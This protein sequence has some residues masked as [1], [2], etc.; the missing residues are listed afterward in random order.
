MAPSSK[1]P[2]LAKGCLIT[3]Y[4][5]KLNPST[6]TQ[7]SEHSE[8][9]SSTRK[10]ADCHSKAANDVNSETDSNSEFENDDVESIDDD[11]TL[12]VEND[13]TETDLCNCF[14]CTSNDKY[15]PTDTEVW[16]R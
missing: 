11:T 8:H 9:S 10:S 4:F 6:V 13:S 14:C 12:P 15:Q 5:H 1:K 2:R 3:T 16:F 7:T